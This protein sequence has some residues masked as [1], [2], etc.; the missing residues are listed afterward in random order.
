MKAFHMKSTVTC[1]ETI[2]RFQNQN[3]NLLAMA[4]KNMFPYVHATDA[5]NLLVLRALEQRYGF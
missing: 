4:Q 5:S 3:R 1:R 2:R